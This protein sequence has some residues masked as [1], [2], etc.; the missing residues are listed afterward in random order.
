MARADKT[1]TRADISQAVQKRI[2][3]SGN[4]ISCIVNDF[5]HRIAH[6]IGSGEDVKLA[7]FG[8]FLVRHRARR[9]ARNPK[10][11]QPAIVPE[12]NAVL[13]RPGARLKESVGAR[14]AEGE[15]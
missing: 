2:G 9:T 6:R 10:T 11:G 12:R 4:E 15:I 7:G 13:F 5:F 3:L 1:L 8:T 14:K